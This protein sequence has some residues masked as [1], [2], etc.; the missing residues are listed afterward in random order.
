M[1]RSKHLRGRL[2]GTSELSTASPIQLPGL[3]FSFDL[4]RLR[5]LHLS[6]LYTLN[7]D[8]SSDD[9]A[10]AQ[11]Y[12]SSAD[13]SIRIGYGIGP[14]LSLNIALQAPAL[15]GSGVYLNPV[16]VVNAASS[17]PF[18]SQVSPGEFLTLYGS[19]LAPATDSAS[20]P[21]RPCFTEC[22]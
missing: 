12:V 14:Y 19:G 18:T 7:S 13:G 3:E 2:S 11:H 16:G 10:F 20:V 4:R 17:A 1:G 5:Q 6:R 21:F 15:S 9:S 8:G 22:R